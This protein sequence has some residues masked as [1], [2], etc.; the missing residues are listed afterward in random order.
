M[1]PRPSAANSKPAGPAE[2][3]P[4]KKATVRFTDRQWEQLRAHMYKHN[5]KLQALI[6][7][8]LADKLDDFDA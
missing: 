6:I 3:S 7:S 2:A 1:S 8:S 4:R 5:I